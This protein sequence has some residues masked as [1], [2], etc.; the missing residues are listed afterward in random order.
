MTADGIQGVI[1]KG[2]GGFYYVRDDGGQEYTLRARGIFRKQKITPLIGDRV[3]VTPGEGE[4][5]GWIDE[6]LPRKNALVRPPVANLNCLMIVIAPTPKPDLLLT[7]ML[8]VEARKQNIAPV[9]VINKADLDLPFCEQIAAEYNQTGY[10]VLITS[11]NQGTGLDDLGSRF[12]QGICCMAGQSGVGKSSLVAAVTGIELNTG[13]ISR[14]N[15]RGKHTT[16]HA[17]LLIKNGFQVLDTAGFSLLNCSEA[18]EPVLLKDFYP[19]FA[20]YES[21]CRFQPCYH[22]S[23]PGC[24]VLQ[25]VRD[26]QLPQERV[27][28]YHQLLASAK[29]A[30]K[31]R[32]E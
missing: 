12:R 25:A 10:P 23:E 11:V 32:Y 20:P 27:A 1:F 5:D 17:E 6:I 3:R 29:E 19:E 31:G 13:E 14:R 24:A 22:L 26:G 16:R 30:W 4:E 21:Q 7:D 18:E 15:E 28:R 9:L 8:M 2:I